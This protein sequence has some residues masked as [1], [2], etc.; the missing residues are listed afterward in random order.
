MAMHWRAGPSGPMRGEAWSELWE[1]IELDPGNQWTD[2]CLSALFTPSALARGGG[3][4][5]MSLLGEASS[6]LNGFGAKGL[7]RLPGERSAIERAVDS[8]FGTGKGKPDSEDGCFGEEVATKLLQL[9]ADPSDPGAP[10]GMDAL[11]LCA[12]LERRASPSSVMKAL[13]KSGRAFPGRGALLARLST[14]SGLSEKMVDTLADAALGKPELGALALL[15]SKVGSSALARAWIVR[16]MSSSPDAKAF[17]GDGLLGEMVAID[18]GAFACLA[19]A[20]AMR[21]QGLEP[22]KADRRALLAHGML[23]DMERCDEEI[24]AK[25][26]QA[27]ASKEPI[28]GSL[29]DGEMGKACVDAGLGPTVCVADA[30]MARALSI[31][32]NERSGRACGTWALAAQRLDQL[33]Y[34]SEMLGG[35]AGKLL[36]KERSISVEESVVARAIGAQGYAKIEALALLGASRLAAKT[37]APTKRL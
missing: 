37:T 13:A 14:G 31:L 18:A 8:R 10:G 36:E 5:I 34:G 24:L 7:G 19:V 26:A 12:G 29:L 35:L 25:W 33:G 32:G 21:E 15:G 16:L 4:D 11:A 28:D 22:S 6:W 30:L 20:G 1:G 2:S 27:G 3:A 23:G 9:G 17:A